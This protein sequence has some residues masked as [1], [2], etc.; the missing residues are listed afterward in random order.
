MCATQAGMVTFQTLT[1][2]A[3]ETFGLCY[4]SSFGEHLEAVRHVEQFLA[5]TSRT[6]RGQVLCEQQGLTWPEAEG[7]LPAELLDL[8]EDEVQFLR[9]ALKVKPSDRATAYELFGY[10][11]C[12]VPTP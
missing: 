3:L 10:A 8:Q 1:V 12:K 9:A 5:A 2:C 4:T 11:F 6:E 7:Q